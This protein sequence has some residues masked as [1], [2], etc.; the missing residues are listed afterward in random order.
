MPDQIS[1][2]AFVVVIPVNEV[3]PVDGLVPLNSNVA[4]VV[5]VGAAVNP[6][7]APATPVALAVI[8]L[9]V[10]ERTNVLVAFYAA[11]AKAPQSNVPVTEM[12]FVLALLAD[13]MLVSN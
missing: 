8:N 10:P 5:K 3:N 9:P 1:V 7:T 4:P 6:E 2:Y 13:V 11:A 12:A